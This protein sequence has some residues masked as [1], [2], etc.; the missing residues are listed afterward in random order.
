[1]NGEPSLAAKLRQFEAFV[2]GVKNPDER[3]AADALL[4]M[5]RRR[6][7][8]TE[9]ADPP[10]EF[11]FSMQDRW[12]GQLFMA[13]LRRYGLKPYRYRGQR[14]TTIMARVSR[15]FVHETLWP[16]FLE[17]SSLLSSHLEV[18]A[19]RIIGETVWNDASEAEVRTTPPQLP[20][21]EW[22]GAPPAS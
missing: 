13:L 9:Q 12:S 10:E 22:G 21:P 14:R 2:A 6:I 15:R 3:A 8:D 1:M 11:R 16:E 20:A 4:D 7:R 19:Q 18:V 17:L 5:V